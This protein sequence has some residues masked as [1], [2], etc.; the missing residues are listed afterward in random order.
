MGAGGVLGAAFPSAATVASLAALLPCG[1]EARE[2]VSCF[3]PNNKCEGEDGD[4]GVSCTRTEANECPN[5]ESAGAM[6]LD[7]CVPL[8]RGG[9]RMTT[10]P[11]PWWPWVAYFIV[12]GLVIAAIVRYWKSVQAGARMEEYLDSLPWYDS[13]KPAI[14]SFEVKV[15]GAGHWLANTMAGN[16][17]SVPAPAGEPE[18]EPMAEIQPLTAPAAA[19]APAPEAAAA[20]A[21]APVPEVPPAEGVAPS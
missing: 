8:T 3:Y 12:L 18:P 5:S 17:E 10:C 4:F 7:E 19:P 14:H 20:A 9:S 21:P 15:A 13:A 1:V 11:G 16:K 6:H 2:V